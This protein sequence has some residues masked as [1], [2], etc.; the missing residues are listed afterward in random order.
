MS[1]ILVVGCDG[2]VGWELCRTLATLGQVRAMN[3]AQ[4]DLADRGK[5]RQYLREA[6]PD[7]TVNAAAYTNVDGAE[8]DVAGANAINAAAPQILAEEMRRLNG[9]FIHYSTDYV[10]DGQKKAPYTEEDEPNPVNVYGASKLAGERAVRDVGGAYLI[11]RTSWVYGMRGKNFLRTTV[12]LAGERDELR[13]VDD[14]IGAPTWSRSI[15]EATG[16]ILARAGATT[17]ERRGFIAERAGVYHFSSAGQTSWYGFAKQI[18]ECNRSSLPRVPLL[19]PITTAEFGA[20]ADRPANSLLS[21]SK[22]RSAFGVL[23]PPWDEALVLCQ[24]STAA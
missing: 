12:R 16:Q 20:K 13:I 21:H 19:T 9:I 17:E 7:L 1:R 3:R 24:E 14:Q 8:S 10:F 15:A 6:A 11:L 23:P 22:I 2:Q 4:L 18:V 5:I